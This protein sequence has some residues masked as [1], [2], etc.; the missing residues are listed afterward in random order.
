VARYL[1]ATVFT[2]CILLTAAAA[3]CTVMTTPQLFM[4]GVVALSLLAGVAE[5]LR[6]TA[7]QMA[8]E[9]RRAEAASW[10]SAIDGAVRTLSLL[11]AG[12]STSAHR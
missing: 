3:C 5:P 12:A 1:R 6:A 4:P 7:I 8:V 9:S 11:L 10:A 2:Q